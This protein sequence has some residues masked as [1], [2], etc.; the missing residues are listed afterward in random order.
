M[1][2]YV[3]P[4][5]TNDNIN[6]AMISAKTSG[7]TLIAAALAALVERLEAIVAVLENWEDRG[8]KRQDF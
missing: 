7:A 4:N 8:I 6:A 3:H 2:H 5:I 1:R